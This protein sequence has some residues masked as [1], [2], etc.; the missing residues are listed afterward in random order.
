MTQG[1]TPHPPVIDYYT[2]KHHAAS[3]LPGVLVAILIAGGVVVPTLVM[4]WLTVMGLLALVV[5]QHDAVNWPLTSRWDAMT[6]LAHPLFAWPFYT[7]ALVAAVAVIR[8]IRNPPLAAMNPWVRVPLWLGLAINVQYLLVVAVAVDGSWAIALGLGDA[9]G[10]AIFL[11][12]A[13]ATGQKVKSAELEEGPLPTI[14]RRMGIGLLAWF[15]C[16]I[17][18]GVGLVLYDGD[19][20]ELIGQLLLFLG[21][22]HLQIIAFSSALLIVRALAPTQEHRR[23]LPTW[24]L[25]YASSWTLCGDMLVWAWY[26]YPMH[27][28]HSYIATAASRGHRQWVGSRLLRLPDGQEIIVN[29][30]LHRLITLELLLAWRSPAVHR[31]LRGVYDRVGPALAAGLTSPWLADVAYVGLKP[32]EWM[33]AGI[34]WVWL[35]SACR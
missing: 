14:S 31:P 2:P 13:I 26:F 8:L 29:R 17:T 25:A 30:Q 18:A 7:L 27:S 1:S 35:R 16:I 34:C 6:V 11:G 23:E 21:L 32:L 22:P 4:G 19:A 12:F 33:A 9:V 28:G 15:G 5:G 24:L 10:A 20:E 3:R